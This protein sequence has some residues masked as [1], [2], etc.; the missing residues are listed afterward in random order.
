MTRS[1]PKPPARP[2]GGLDQPWYAGDPIPV[3]EVVQSDGD[4]AWQMFNEIARQH[5]ARFAPTAPMTVPPPALGDGAWAVTQPALRA[6]LQAQKRAAQ[7][8][9]TLDAAMLVARR[10]NRVCP[11]PVRWTEFFALLPPR[12]TARGELRPPAPVTG[13]AWDVTPPLTKRLCFREHIEWAESA[14][15]LESAMAFMQSMR[16]DEWLHMG[17]D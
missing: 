12:K 3:P 7:P 5:D 4:T 16:E 8:L 9:I 1:G 10:N 2:A 6:P 11:R 13:P 14:G 17:E 15:L